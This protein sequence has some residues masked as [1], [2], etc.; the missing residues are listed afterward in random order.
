MIT[1]CDTSVLLDI[2][3]D[4]PRFAERSEIALNRAL[5]EGKVVLCDAVWAEARALFAEENRL[6]RIISDLGLEYA[7]PSLA[8]AERAGAVWRKYR[9]RGGKRDR[10]VA[11]FLIGAH[12][13]ADCDR[14]LTRDRGFFRTYFS[15]LVIVEP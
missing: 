15:G 4:A 14:L 6:A 5:A 3:L 7:A 12:A 10:I 8:A 9:A 2:F 1:A 13:L 11:D